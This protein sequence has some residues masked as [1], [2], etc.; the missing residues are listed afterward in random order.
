[1]EFRRHPRWRLAV[2]LCW[3]R[4]H[5][6]TLSLTT[7]CLRVYLRRE[8]HLADVQCLFVNS[9]SRSKRKTLLN[10]AAE[11]SSSQTGCT[12]ETNWFY[13][14]DLPGSFHV[15]IMRNIMLALPNYF[16]RMPDQSFILSG[17]NEP[18]DGSRA[19]DKLISG[20]RADGWAMVHLPYG[21]EVTID[22]GKALPGKVGAWRAWWVDTKCG[23]KELDQSGKGQHVEKFVSPSEGTLKDDWLLLVECLPS[24]P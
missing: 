22:I 12:A 24:V 16:S 9:W 10:R 3:V 20:T 8:F 2:A 18:I 23:A 13:E 21:G 4:I 5:T 7:Q 11:V 19:G 17:T 6:A 14:L 15:G 1:M